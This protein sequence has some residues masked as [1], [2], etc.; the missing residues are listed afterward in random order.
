LTRMS[1]APS[2]KKLKMKQML[3]EARALKKSKN[4]VCLIGLKNTRRAMNL[5][6]LSKIYFMANKLRRQS[7]RAVKDKKV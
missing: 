3:P 7:W 4:G 2:V 1:P 6:V 5:K